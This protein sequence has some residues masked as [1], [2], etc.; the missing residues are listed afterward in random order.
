MAYDAF[1]GVDPGKNG[2]IAVLE[3]QYTDI[4]AWINAEIFK[5]DRPLWLGENFVAA[6]STGF[7]LIEKVHAMPNQGV[8]S[9]FNFGRNFGQLEML[10]DWQ[11][12]NYDYVTP[13]TWQKHFKL[14]KEKGETKT[15]KKNRH[16]ALAQ[17]LFPDIKVTHTNA[18]ALLIAWYCRE[19]HG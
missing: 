5:T 3:N 9:M 19:I 6:V 8:T 2:A 4:D 11:C 18:D 14:L 17:K 7:A 12:E 13:Q 15:Q 16:K 10:I 1:I